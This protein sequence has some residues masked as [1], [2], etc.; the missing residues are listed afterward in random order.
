MK[1]EVW[2]LKNRVECLE[3]QDI[4]GLIAEDEIPDAFDGTMGGA[5]PGR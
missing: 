3:R 5:A 1:E 2:R 4:R